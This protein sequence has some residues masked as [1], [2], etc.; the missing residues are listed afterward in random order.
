MEIGWI[1]CAIY[2]ANPKRLTDLFFFFNILILN[3]F[4]KYETIET[5]A[6]AFLALIILAIGRV[7]H[8]LLNAKHIFNLVP[9]TEKNKQT[10]LGAVVRTIN[11]NVF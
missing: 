3:Y 10:V 2:Q 6:R 1:G 8:S 5:H 4:F 11:A 9:W 7:P